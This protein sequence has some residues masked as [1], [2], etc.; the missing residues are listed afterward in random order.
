MGEDDE[1]DPLASKGG[2]YGRVP[3]TVSAAAEEEGLIGGYG[4][5]MVL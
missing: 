5:V 3:E 2:R 4:G 1:H